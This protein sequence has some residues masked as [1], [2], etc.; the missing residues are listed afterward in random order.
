MS[1]TTAVLESWLLSVSSGYVCDN[2]PHAINECDVTTKARRV[3][4][5]DLPETEKI[6][7]SDSPP[8]IFLNLHFALNYPVDEVVTFMDIKITVFWDV[9]LGFFY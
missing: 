9:T 7:F 6:K 5:H 8:K 2:L 3:W 4:Y 1:I